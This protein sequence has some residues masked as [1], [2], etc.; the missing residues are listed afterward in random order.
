MASATRGPEVWRPGSYRAD[1]TQPLD[2]GEVIEIV[3][4]VETHQMRDRLDAPL[5]VDAMMG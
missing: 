1:A 2:L 5:R 3:P 4:G